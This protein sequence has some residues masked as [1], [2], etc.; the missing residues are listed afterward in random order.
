MCLSACRRWPWAPQTGAVRRLSLSGI[1]TT[2]V[3]GTLAGLIEIV[4]FGRQAT[5]WARRVGVLVALCV[6]A[7]VGGALVVEVPWA[8]PI[9]AL[10]AVSVV[11]G[12]AALYFRGSR[13]D[14]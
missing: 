2:Y 8:A 5:G 12:A 3:T 14:G 6:G 1:A 9:A 13:V 11:V 7:A 10:A 4:A